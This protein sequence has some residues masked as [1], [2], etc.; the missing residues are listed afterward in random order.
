MG[1]TINPYAD[2]E[3]AYLTFHDRNQRAWLAFDTLRVYN[4]PTINEMYFTNLW[5]ER[6]PLDEVDP[7]VYSEAIDV[8]MRIHTPDET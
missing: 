2:S 5:N 7:V 6:I 8:A 1:W 4:R 3:H